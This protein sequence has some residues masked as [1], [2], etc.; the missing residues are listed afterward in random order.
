MVQIIKVGF[1]QYSNYKD[2][3]NKGFQGLIAKF[4]ELTQEDPAL[5]TVQYKIFID[6][7]L[8]KKG[9]CQSSHLKTHLN[10]RLQEIITKVEK[11]KQVDPSL[12]TI[13]YDIEI[14]GRY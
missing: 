13:N 5:K 11:H 3:M 9:N 1:C 14:V 6:G 2:Y 8:N 12:K 10:R 4:E 7:T